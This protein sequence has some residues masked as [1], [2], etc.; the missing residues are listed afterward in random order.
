MVWTVIE[1]IGTA[2]VAVAVGWI[3]FDAAADRIRRHRERHS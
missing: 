1:M 2:V 3:A